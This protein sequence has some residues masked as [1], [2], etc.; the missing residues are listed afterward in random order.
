MSRAVIDRYA[1]EFDLN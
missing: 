1:M